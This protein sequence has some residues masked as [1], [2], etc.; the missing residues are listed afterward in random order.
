ME[1]RP[2]YRV[3]AAGLDPR[4][5]RLIE[6]VFKHSQYN[7]YAFRFEPRPDPLAVDIL[8]VNPLAPEG[9]R[10]VARARSAGRNLPVVSAVP[11]GATSNARHAISIDRLT[12]QLLPILNR[13]VELD[14][15]RAKDGAPGA[16]ART[17]EADGERSTREFLREAARKSREGDDAREA[18]MRARVAA[19]ASSSGAG[20]SPPPAQAEPVQAAPAPSNLVAF[21]RSAEPAPPRIRVLVVDDSPTVR[22][23][24]SIAFTRMN[25]LCDA[26]AG[27][28][29]ALARLAEAHYDL[30]LVDVVMPGVDGYKLTRQ[31]RRRHR[32]VPVIILTSRS[33][34]FDLAR[35]ALAGC[36]SYLVKPVA[37]RQLEAAVVRQLRKSLAIDDPSA[38]LRLTPDPQAL[39]AARGARPAPDAAQ[40]QAAPRRTQGG[41]GE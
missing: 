40:A 35:G 8:I 29:E 27:A 39:A 36:N 5:V 22:R 4:D 16:G 33:S 24:L 41:A 12:L 38:L 1:S 23:Q 17:A 26:A 15:R 37:L 25:A 2:E 18:A 19:A 34:P 21:P 7:R 28:D 9:L 3:A 30:V 13:V 20:H 10:A 11:H 32:G 31:I 14:L 6:I